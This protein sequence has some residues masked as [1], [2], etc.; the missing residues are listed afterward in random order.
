[1]YAQKTGINSNSFLG[2]RN[3][4]IDIIIPAYNEEARIMP[5]LNDIIDFIKENNLLWRIIVS[6]DGNDHTRD[7]VSKLKDEYNFILI[8]ESNKRSGKGSAIKRTISMLD[9]DYV[10]LMDADNSIN[11]AIILENLENGLK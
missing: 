10:I 8:S 5:V 7:M 11:F 2:Y 1:M 4:K 3:E 6:I 9:S